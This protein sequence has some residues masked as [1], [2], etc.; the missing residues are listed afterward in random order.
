MPSESPATPIHG[1]PQPDNNRWRPPFPNP[2]D[3]CFDYRKLVEQ[4]GGI[5]D[6]SGI[7][8]KV[9]IVGAGITGLTTARELLRCGLRDITLFEQS[10]RVGGRHLTV[11]D[12]SLPA[13]AGSTPFEMGAMRLPF[14]NRRGEPPLEGRSLQAYYTKLFQLKISD[15]ANPGSAH[16]NGT[17]IFLR[18]GLLD[19]QTTPQMLIWNNHDGQTP[20]PGESL[21]RVYG[22][23][24]AFV[25]RLDKQ[26]QTHYAGPGWESLWAAIAQRYESLSFRSLLALAPLENWNPSN[27][28]DFGGVGMNAEESAIFYAIG[29]GDGSWGAFY[30]A[31]CLYPIRTALFGFSDQL[32]L[33]HGRVDD[34]GKPLPAP[35]LHQYELLDSHGLA[36]DGPRYLGVAALDECMLFLDIDKPG[37]S[38]F[39]HCKQRGAGFSSQS[40]VTGLS[41]LTNQKI[42]VH[43]ERQWSDPQRRLSCHEDFD[44]VVLTLPSW[45]IETTI[46]LVGFT[47]QMLP[48]QIRNAYQTAHWETSC[49]VFAPLQKRFFSD[50]HGIPQA[51]V[52]DSLIHDVYTY[53][54]NESYPNDCILLSYTWEDDATK[55]AIFSDRELVAKC[56]AELDRILLRAS[57]IN[58]RISPYIDADKARVH[59]WITDRN[60]LGAARLYRPGTYYDVIDLMS[61]N[62]NYSA[63]SGLYLCGES[64]CVDAGWTEPCLRGAVDTVIHLCD[65]IGARFNGG[66]RLNDYPIYASRPKTPGN[67]Q[68]TSPTSGNTPQNSE[69]KADR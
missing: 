54:Y 47:E 22:K 17:G 49:K 56:I 29:I 59:R 46:Q 25:A 40:R 66:F 48:F 10:S 23:W 36:F 28:G 32:Q 9:A 51:M 52:T 62:R 4:P 18:D 68:N 21:Q 34:R 57:N 55:L 27:P 53:R 35:H 58:R 38:F 2:P 65:R 64:F 63:G 13:G 30:D 1:T 39:D 7:N 16:V 50:A 45:L 8:H 44:S 26:I 31:C 15:F 67:V 5:A 12:R 60:A 37:S 41:K 24:R 14:F 33:I 19:T 61:Y 20:P 11:V 3:L 6:A 42:R 43:Y 69:E